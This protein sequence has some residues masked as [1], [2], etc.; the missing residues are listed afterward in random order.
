MENTLKLL[1]VAA[2]GAACMAASGCVETNTAQSSSLSEEPAPA[3]AEAPP[4]A[5]KADA[6][7]TDAADAP[8]E[9]AENDPN[10]KVCKRIKSTGSNFTRRLCQTR[11]Q[12]DAEAKAAKEAVDRLNRKNL[13]GCTVDQQC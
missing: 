8:N 10:E 11:A 12:W 7:E 4:A 13:E 5:E 2:F 3:A 9:V 1:M 6:A